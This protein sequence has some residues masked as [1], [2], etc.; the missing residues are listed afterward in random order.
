MQ[1]F[2]VSRDYMTS[3]EIDL[4]PTVRTACFALTSLLG[5]ARR[6]LHSSS[7][8]ELEST[9]G[10]T[11]ASCKLESGKEAVFYQGVL[12][13]GLE[14][15]NGDCIRAQLS[16]CFCSTTDKSS[17]AQDGENLFWS[18]VIVRGEPNETYGTN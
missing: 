14:T 5:H 4:Y 2:R 10:A 8:W 13:E 18:V 9:K 7:H 17:R 11:N 16:I 3:T 6:H 1:I 15:Q 12:G